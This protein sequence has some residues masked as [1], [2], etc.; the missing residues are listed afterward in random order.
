MGDLYWTGGTSGDINVAANYSTAAI[1]VGN[2]RLFFT[3]NGTF[4]PNVNMAALTA[5][6]L[7]LLYV[8]PQFTQ[9]I[10]TSGAPL[11][12]SADKVIH[13]GSGCLYYKDGGGTTDWLIVDSPNMT[14]AA[15]LTGTTI[16]HIHV[17]SGAVKCDASLG[18]VALARIDQ[19]AHVT[20]EAG[21]G[22]I[23]ALWMD[24]GVMTNSAVVTTGIVTGGV[25]T[26]ETEEIVTLWLGNGTVVYNAPTT[27]GTITTAYVG[28]RGKLN[29]LGNAL[30]KTITTL[31]T[32]P[33]ATLLYRSDLHTFT[34]S[35]R[36]DDWE[37]LLGI[38]I[39]EGVTP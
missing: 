31:Y 22:T 39:P 38:S 14:L 35:Y 8:G 37:P 18:A 10:G 21:A 33:G 36:M 24:G 3:T 5:V 29:L 9:D 4:A 6:D 12:I 28:A 26:K 30:A 15:K 1:P 19:N 23:T 25:L 11:D 13:Q 16:S 27:T 17:V 34:T 2:D 20:W 32:Q 7:D